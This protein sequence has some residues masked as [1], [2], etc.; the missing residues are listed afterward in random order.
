[1]AK[2]SL[3]PYKMNL[4]SDL[5][6]RLSEAA[7]RAGRSLS[8]EIITRLEQTLEHDD[9]WSNAL[10]NIDD[11]ILRIERL[12]KLEQRVAALE[13]SVSGLQR[14]VIPEAVET[15]ARMFPKKE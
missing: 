1:M 14:F 4:P 10:E 9:E 8:S 11:A 7:Q 6:D 15:A 2:E 12:E 13:Y 5:K 3:T